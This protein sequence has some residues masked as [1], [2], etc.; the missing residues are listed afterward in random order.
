MENYLFGKDELKKRV[1]HINENVM[2]YLIKNHFEKKKVYKLKVISGIELECKY[3]FLPVE[4]YLDKTYIFRIRINF[5]NC[6]YLSIIEK[7]LAHSI[8][9]EYR[10]M[11]NYLLKRQIFA[12]VEDDKF[13]LVF[14]YNPVLSILNSDAFSESNYLLKKYF[15]QDYITDSSFRT[16]D[17]FRDFSDDEIMSIIS[18]EV[19]IVLDFLVKFDPN[20]YWL[21]E[22]NYEKANNSNNML[23]NSNNN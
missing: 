15:N 11:G 13:T 8:E 2:N 1:E 17:V 7:A 21:G 14:E 5:K 23:V 3:S 9:D 22:I 10:R 18:S 19:L 4:Y 6:S 12:E 20:N 16:S